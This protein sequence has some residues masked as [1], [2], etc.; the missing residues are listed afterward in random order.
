VAR[1]T[2]QGVLVLTVLAPQLHGDGLV[3]AVGHELDQAA[4]LDGAAGLVLDLRHVRSLS[5]AAF[6]P[7]VSLRRAL[8]ARGGRLVL[9]NL[10]PVVAE[11]FRVTRLVSTSPSSAST[12]EVRPDLAA[13]VAY[14]QST[15]PAAC[16]HNT[17]AR[18]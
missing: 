11:T 14:L 8:Q 17:Y 10:S 2:H 7:L 15:A 5:S 3:R 18:A 16:G 6:R 12:F 13:A 9:C 1:S 4:A